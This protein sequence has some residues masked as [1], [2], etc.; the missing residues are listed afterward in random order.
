MLVAFAIHGRF[1]SCFSVSSQ[2]VGWTVDTGALQIL[3]HHMVWLRGRWGHGRPRNASRVEL[4]STLYSWCTFC[5]L[6]MVSQLSKNSRIVAYL[7]DSEMTPA[8]ETDSTSSTL[9]VPNGIRTSTA[10]TAFPLTMSTSRFRIAIFLF[11][12]TNL[13]S[14]EIHFAVGEWISL[15]GVWFVWNGSDYKHIFCSLLETRIN[16]VKN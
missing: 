1:G 5:T 14:P 12:L 13:L 16:L 2:T 4:I 3:M 11:S 15:V 8:D 10:P 6:V 7:G 9:F